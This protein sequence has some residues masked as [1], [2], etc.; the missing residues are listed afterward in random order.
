MVSVT[1]LLISFS[2]QYYFI[3]WLIHGLLILKVSLVACKF[4]ATEKSI[5]SVYMAM[6]LV[7]CSIHLSNNGD[8]RL[9]EYMYVYVWIS[10]TVLN[11]ASSEI[12]K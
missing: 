12:V 11:P 8:V 1:L 4:G 9:L 7:Y 2:P 3:V 10:M 6:S 5:S